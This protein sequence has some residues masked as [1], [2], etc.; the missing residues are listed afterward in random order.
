MSDRKFLTNKQIRGFE[1]YGIGP[2]SGTDH[3][4]GNYSIHSS[5]STTVPNGLPEKWNANSILFLDAANVW[6]VDFDSSLDSDKIRSSAGIALD[7]ISPLGPLNFT[8]A[9]IISSAPG[10]VEE[11]FSFQIGSSF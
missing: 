10:D 5:F 3:I 11:N 9:E 6:S 1:N 4:G 8:F 2:I 7:W